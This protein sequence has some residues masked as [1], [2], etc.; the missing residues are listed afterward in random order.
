MCF[1]APPSIE[2]KDFRFEISNSGYLWFIG[3][4]LLPVPLQQSQTPT[5]TSAHPGSI[6]LFTLLFSLIEQRTVSG[7]EYL[8]R[9]LTRARV[10]FLESYANPI[11][12]LL[13]RFPREIP[14]QIG[15]PFPDAGDKKFKRRPVLSASTLT[16][17]GLRTNGRLSPGRVSVLV[18]CAI[19][20]VEVPPQ[21]AALAISDNLA[22]GQTS[23]VVLGSLSAS[24]TLP[25]RATRR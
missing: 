20:A 2:S 23:V 15:F 1:V 5:G 18:L 22:D 3:W 4:A 14:P 7:T 16:G 9:F 6:I 10:L 8:I 19:L 13:L 25:Q 24:L 11:R 17:Q 21:R 12:S